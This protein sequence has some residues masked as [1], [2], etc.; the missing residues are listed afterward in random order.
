MLAALSLVLL[1]GALGPP[2]VTWV[3]RKMLF[4]APGAQE[5]DP[6]KLDA[7]MEV[8]ALPSGTEAFLLS[9][10]QNINDKAPL[11]VFTHGN[12]ELI[13]SWVHQFDE[14][15]NWGFAVLLVEYPGY[16]RSPGTP[17]QKT[18]TR[19]MSEVQTWV[20]K[21]VDIDPNGI[22]AYGRSLGGGAATIFA[23]Q[24]RTAAIILESTFSS[25]SKIAKSMGAPAFLIRDPFDSLSVVRK[26]KKPI[27]IIHGTEDRVIPF[28]HAEE[29]RDAAKNATFIQLECG[30]N[31][32]PSQW[33][34]IRKFLTAS[35]VLPTP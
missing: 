6:A 31:D 24:G 8:I 17:S 34:A 21:R 26:Y 30:H 15:R 7:N 12:G 16:G 33:S 13:D 11:I 25:V 10:T 35:G 2:A 4:P 32:C 18:I 28:V 19:T 27:L 23:D 29:L 20:G 5:A 3:A 9:P 14:P 22:V 1:V